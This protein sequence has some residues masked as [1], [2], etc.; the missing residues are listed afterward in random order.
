MPH[1]RFS[2]LRQLVNMHNEIFPERKVSRNLIS[3][4][5]KEE[6][7]LR[8]L[9]PKNNS[10]LLLQQNYKDFEEIFLK[11][12]IHLL[13]RKK[14]FIFIDESKFQLK[15]DRGKFWVSKDN[16][17]IF[18]QPQERQKTNLLLAISNSKVLY[19]ELEKK[20][21]DGERFRCFLE[22]LIRKLPEKMLRDHVIIIDNAKPHVAQQTKKIMRKMKLKVLFNAPYK[23]EYSVVDYTFR[24]LKNKVYSTLF[25]TM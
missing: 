3:R 19:Y 17:E 12:F 18:Q 24:R 25:L 20:N 6:M 5:L 4:C 8:Y 1:G 10:I 16:P 15:N 23:C 21:I 14:K 11:T 22:N 2:S 7:G 9:R 13:N